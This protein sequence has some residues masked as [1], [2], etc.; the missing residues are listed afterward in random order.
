MKERNRYFISKKSIYD[1]A[2]LLHFP[3]PDDSAKIILI[4]VNDNK[5]INI[6]PAD[7]TEG[8]KVLLDFQ[9]SWLSPEF[10]YFE[11]EFRQI[12]MPP[13]VMDQMPEIIKRIADE[14]KYPVED[15]N[16]MLYL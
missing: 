6:Y 8:R 9:K 15:I 14:T 11:K 5:R 13:T 4:K 3:K 1:Y 7:T 12:I 10:E 16:K 2:M